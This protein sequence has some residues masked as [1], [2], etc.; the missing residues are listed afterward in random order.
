VRANEFTILNESVFKLNTVVDFIYNT[1]FKELIDH[2]NSG[3]EVWPLKKAKLYSNDLPK[4]K[5]INLANES[6]PLIIY[7]N[8]GNGNVYYP[9]DGAMSLSV[10]ENAYDFVRTYGTLP[11]AVNVLKSTGK[12]EKAKALINEFTP[13][14][15]KGS[16]HHELN[17]WLDDTL[18]NQHLQKLMTKA[19]DADPHKRSNIVR[20]GN[21]DV[22]LTNY[23]R[24]AQIHSIVQLKRQYG[25]Q[26]NRLSFEEM[27]RLNP[28]LEHIYDNA[29]EG[30]WLDEW[31]Q[32]LLRR[33]HREGLLGKAMTKS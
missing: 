16:I 28:S 26:W 25:R 22:A 27:I 6:N 29:K 2:V 4:N 20:Q 10:N 24:E 8:S 23:E 12:P 18:R 5:Y 17:H 21:P 33:M 14:R 1:Y 30:G 7:I 11:T 32:L 31:K 15:I 19:G 3:L 9:N 13:A